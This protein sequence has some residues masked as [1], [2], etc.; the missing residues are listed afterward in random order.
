MKVLFLTGGDREKAFNFLL[1]K[2]INII[3]LITPIKTKKNY[4]FEKCILT[5]KKYG[6]KTIS[7]SKKN[8]EEKLNKLDF[9]LIISCGFTYILSKKILK[10]AKVDAINVHPTL[11]PK[12]RGFRS[13]PFVIINGEKETGVTIHKITK[14]MD[15]GKIYLQKK[16]KISKFDTTK[17]IFRKCKSIEPSMIYNV[18]NLIKKNKLNPKKQNEKLSSTFNIIR[19]P[20]DSKIN[21]NWSLRKLYNYIRA[22]DYNDYPAH[23]YIQGH[24]VLIKLTREK[25]NDPYDDLI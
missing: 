17:S 23:F 20:K 22:C 10:M 16:F 12:Y 4:R 6:V 24:K 25:K 19:T 5:A 9:D 13:G 11:L 14:S 8:I 2:N 18:I 1:K 3:A 7:V 21:I 15:K